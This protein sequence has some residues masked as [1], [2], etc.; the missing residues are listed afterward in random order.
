M[1]IFWLCIFL[2]EKIECGR[3][4]T[5]AKI[6]GKQN[7]VF[8]FK[9]EYVFKFSLTDFT[10]LY[11]ITLPFDYTVK[12]GKYTKFLKLYFTLFVT[13]YFA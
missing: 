6:S 9:K 12:V 10:L 3:R 5:L 7:S 13:A 8:Y 4:N 2:C 11:K 1:R